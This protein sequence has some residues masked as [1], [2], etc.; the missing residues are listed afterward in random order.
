MKRFITI[1]LILVT[2]ICCY[3]QSPEGENPTAFN[4]VI[5]MHGLIH[6]RFESSFTDSVD[7]QGKFSSTP[8]KS[9]FRIRRLELRA[10]I[11]LTAK[12]SGVIRVQF[13]DLKTS[14]P[15]RAI[16]LAYFQYSWNDQLNIRGGQMKMP[17]ELDELTSPEDLRMID[18]GSTNRIFVSNYLASY[19][20]G[21]MIYGTFLKSKSPLNYYAGIFNGSERSLPYDDNSQKNMVGRIEFTP[22][23]SLR[24]AINDQLAGIAK[25]V[26]GNSIGGDLSFQ[27]KLSEKL[28]LIAEGEYIQGPNILLY[29]SSTDSVKNIDDFMM[30]GYFAQGLLRFH[31]LKPWLR[32]FEIGGKYEH[33]DPWTSKSPDEDVSGN[34]YN[35]ITGGIGFVF[36]P[37]NDARL[38][39]NVIHTDY[40]TE[41]AGS[42]KNNLM[43]VTQLQLKL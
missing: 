30:N 29:A 38:Q 18:R 37:D 28:F 23:K 43:F 10:D 24:L 8:L 40:E 4:P 26:T 15:G 11:Q 33:T 41:F 16:E 31:I 21:L 1:L 22:I 12:W 34:S 19:Q 42:Q 9:N 13:P 6:A 35:T 5:K 39:L 2:T 20:P 32:S 7:V 17:F 27:Q 3:S 25:G 14:T 36:L